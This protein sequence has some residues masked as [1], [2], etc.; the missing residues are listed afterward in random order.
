MTETPDITTERDVRNNKKRQGVSLSYQRVFLCSDGQKK[1]LLD[2]LSI[3]TQI[4]RQGFAS[5]LHGHPSAY[6]AML[7]ACPRI[8]INPF[9]VFFLKNID[10][11]A[12][13]AH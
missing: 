6:E 3:S 1:L 9:S 8:R 5:G 7:P 12:F 2:D 11:Y 13:L 4:I 10:L